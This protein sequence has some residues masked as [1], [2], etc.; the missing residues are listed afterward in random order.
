[1]EKS[2][3]NFQGMNKLGEKDGIKRTEFESVTIVALTG[4]GEIKAS[5]KTGLNEKDLEQATTP[6]NAITAWDHRSTYRDA[7]QNDLTL[8][9]YLK[10]ITPHLTGTVYWEPIPVDNPG[11]VAARLSE[12]SARFDGQQRRFYLPLPVP[13]HPEFGVNSNSLAR[14]L[15][16]SA[17][18]DIDQPG[19][20]FTPGWYTPFDI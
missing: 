5:G 19:N 11:G 15:L 9:Q 17:N 3:L 13:G 12:T 10:T 6:T 4:D 1:M 16:L 18:V 14:S 8:E 2:G 20:R 7:R